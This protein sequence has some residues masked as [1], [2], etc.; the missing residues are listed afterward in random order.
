MQFETKVSDIIQRTQNV[1]SIRFPR[2]S[3]FNYKAG[4]FIFVT[5]KSTKGEVSRYFSISSSPTEKEFIEFTKKLTGSDFSNAMDALKVGDWAKIN[6]PYGSFTFEGDYGKLGML[7]GGIGITPLR[8]ICKYCTDLRLNTDIIL[9]YGNHSEADIVFRKD[10]EQM[11][12]LNKNLKIVLTLDIRSE[13]WTG[14]VGFIDADMVK[15]EMP[16]YMG[17]ILYTCGPPGMVVAMENMLKGL[18]VPEIQVK[19]ERFAG[20]Q[21]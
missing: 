16:D 21:Q 12:E 13:G 15:K 14:P 20:Y 10:L 9:L 7:S 5:I 11:Q 8:S 1:K 19:V 17:R 2:S 3:A 4:Q 18:G 6:G